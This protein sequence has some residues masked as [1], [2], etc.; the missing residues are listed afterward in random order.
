[1]SFFKQLFRKRDLTE[2]L[3]EAKTESKLARVLDTKALTNIGIGAIIGAGVFVLVG[4]VA[5][6]TAGPAIMLSFVV[7]GALCVLAALCYAEFASMAPVEGSAYTY[8]YCTLGEF[9]AWIIAWDLILEYAVAA[10]AVA[11]S[12]SHYLQDLVKLVSKTAGSRKI[13]DPKFGNSPIDYIPQPD[14]SEA[15]GLTGNYVDL[16]AIMIT[17]VLTAVL[18]KGIK[19]SAGFNTVMVYLKVAI[20]LAVIVIGAFYI[21]PANWKPFAPFGYGGVTFFGEPVWG[22]LNEAGKPIGGAGWRCDHLLCF[23]R[24]RRRVGSLGRSKEPV[25]CQVEAAVLSSMF[26]KRSLGSSCFF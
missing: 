8:G 16:P 14:G 5:K 7:A 6:D 20:V 9:F 1:M 22:T 15:L 17:L 26:A 19:E 21:D 10:A 23:R 25:G 11:H 12:W 3:E 13:I 2:L 18:V 24:L 4:K